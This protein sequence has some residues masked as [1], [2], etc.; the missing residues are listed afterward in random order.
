MSSLLSNLE[1]RALE[2]NRDAI[3]EFDESDDWIVIDWRGFESESLEAIKTAVPAS[4]FDYELA[5]SSEELSLSMK[6]RD[7]TA[8]HTYGLVPQNNVR[9]IVDAARLMEDEFEIRGFRERA[10]DDTNSLLLRPTAWWAEIERDYPK[11]ARKL[12][13]DLTEMSRYWGIQGPASATDRARPW[14]AFWR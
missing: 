3:D 2:G 14:W 1:R 12:F 4:Q 8:V 11:Q 10:Q 9:V 13:C 7:R 5:E 6:F